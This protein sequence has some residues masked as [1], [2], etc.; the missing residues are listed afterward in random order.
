MRKGLKRGDIPAD[1]FPGGPDAYLKKM[2]TRG[3]F[4]DGIFLKYFAK[5]LNRDI[6]ILPVHPESCTVVQQFT[7]IKG[8]RNLLSRSNQLKLE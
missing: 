5:I 1:M 3:T 4:A 6:V 2:G 8:G 7:W